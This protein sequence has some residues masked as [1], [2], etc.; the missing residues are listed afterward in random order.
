CDNG[1]VQRALLAFVAAVWLQ[2]ADLDRWPE[3]RGPGASGIAEGPAPVEFGP[4]NKLLWSVELP[5]GH[6][7]PS[8]WGSHVLLTGFDAKS[9][10]LEVVDI[11]RGTGKVRWRRPVQASG[12]EQVHE[13]SSPATATPIID[14]ERVYAYFGSSGVAAFDLEGKPLWT[15]P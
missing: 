13:V 1:R 5:Q 3:Y 11:D 10:P 12:I 4:K 7:S 8:I 9:K 14:G 2:A 15:V 6:S